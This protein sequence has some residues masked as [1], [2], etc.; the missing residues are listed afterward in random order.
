M[1]DPHKA[2]A[3]I[4]EAR[5]VTERVTHEC[6]PSMAVGCA[7]GWLSRLSDDH[8][9]AIL[10]EITDPEAREMTA[11]AMDA[12]VRYSQHADALL[13]SMGIDPK[14]GAID[15]MGEHQ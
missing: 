4:I 15:P 3:L 6:G 8:R 5:R 13:I 7:L 10:I 9:D 12:S 11:L 2:A 1:I 14:T